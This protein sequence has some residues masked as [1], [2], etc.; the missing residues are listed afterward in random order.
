MAHIL[1]IST[2]PGSDPPSMQVP[3]GTYVNK[4]KM[5]ATCAPCN[6]SINQ[7]DLKSV[8]DLAQIHQTMNEPCMNPGVHMAQMSTR[9][10]PPSMNAEYEHTSY[11]NTGQPDVS[12]VCHIEMPRSTHAYVNLYNFFAERKLYNESLS[13]EGHRHE[14][15]HTRVATTVAD[16]P[17]TSH[18]F[19]DG[20]DL[21]YCLLS[22]ELCLNHHAA[23]QLLVCMLP[24]VYKLHLAHP[25]RCA[26]FVIDAG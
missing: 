14:T 11:W 2:G 7:S 6:Q 21:T 15:K 5:C 20:S 25:F 16:I 22:R 18:T 24:T 1:H 4:Y 10:V 19:R 8:R 9:C 12:H 13:I 23:C 26:H 17:S 3:C